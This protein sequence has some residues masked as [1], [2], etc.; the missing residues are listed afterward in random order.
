MSKNQVKE[1][2]KS[3]LVEEAERIARLPDTE[4][5]EAILYAS[6]A[7]LES[8]LDTA[9]HNGSA[10]AAADIAYELGKRA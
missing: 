10:F 6:T 2:G 3:L 1:A 9:K 5:R 8:A 7:L 4:R